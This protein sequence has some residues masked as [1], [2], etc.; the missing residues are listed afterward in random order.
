MF[1]HGLGIPA[2]ITSSLN[3]LLL[4]EAMRKGLRGGERQERR[5]LFSP[6]FSLH[7]GYGNSLDF[8]VI[9]G[10]GTPILSYKSRLRRQRPQ[11]QFFIVSMAS[12][13]T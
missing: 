1:F 3:S 7:T 6:K 2:H 4:S 12:D 10:L 8:S 5:R 11:V 13:S 9:T